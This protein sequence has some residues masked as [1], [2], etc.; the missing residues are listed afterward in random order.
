[1]SGAPGPVGTLEGTHDH[2]PRLL[3]RD[4]VRGTTVRSGRGPDAK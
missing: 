4:P 1:M 3:R 2:G